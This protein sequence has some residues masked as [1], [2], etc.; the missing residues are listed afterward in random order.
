MEKI[1]VVAGATGNLGTRIIKALREK[2]AIV[3][4]LVRSNSDAVKIKELASLGAKIITV[5]FSSSQ[6]L[7][8]SCKNAH[9]VISALSGLRD[10]IIDGQKRLL[11][12]AIAA[13]VKRFIPSDFS[14][15]F[16][17]LE[18][19]ENRNLDLRREFHQYLGQTTIAATSIFNGTFM[20]MLTDKIPMILFK[21][22]KLLYWGNADQSLDFTTMDNTAEFTACVALAESSLRY[23]HIAGDQ[24]TPREMAKVVGGVTGHQFKLFRPGGL[25]FLQ[26]LIKPI[27]FFNP[28]K[29]ELY[30][31]WQGMQYMRDMMSG[32]A[33]VAEYDND[34]Y[35]QIKWTTVR[36]LL[37]SEVKHKTTDN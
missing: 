22:K 36:D 19:G 3:H 35:P 23:Y 12:A 27:K 8:D 1:I 11:N 28:A 34:L 5:D 30:P 29:H 15:D 13:G 24:I 31:A 16:T 20:D 9:C 18:D 33:K 21:Q 32:R 37:L 25:K 14:I 17:N 26:A 4:A 6:Q 7:T 10:V 2:D